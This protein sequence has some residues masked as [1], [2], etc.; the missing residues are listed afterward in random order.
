MSVDRQ[1]DEPFWEAGYR[2]GKDGVFGQPS[3]EFVQLAER[4]PT[5]APV[6][7]VGCGDGR[8][9]LYLAHRGLSVHCF[10]ISASAIEALKR[11]AAEASVPLKSWVADV[12][13][14]R[15]EEHYSAVVTHGVFPFVAREI[16]DAFIHDAKIWTVPGGV[17]VHVVFTDVE[18]VPADLEPFVRNV[19]RDGELQEQYS[20]WDVEVCRSYIKEDEHPGGVRHRH[21]LNKMIAWKPA[22]AV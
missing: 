5:S 7:D 3:E 18:A 19:Y 14:F 13:Q 8:N 16:C 9:A 17:H 1:C 22:H 4:L 15:F 11:R 12:A 6:L 21:A 10:D 2:S 20:D